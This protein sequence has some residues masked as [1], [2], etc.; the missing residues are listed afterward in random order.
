MAIVH[1]QGELCSG[2]D[3]WPARKSTSGSTDVK[4]NGIGVHRKDDLWEEHEKPGSSPEPHSSTL[5]SGSGTVKVNGK[6]MAR[7]GDPIVCGSTVA[8]DGSPNVSCGD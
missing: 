3:T 6:G 8:G 5:E 4:V 7:V 2:H 1:L